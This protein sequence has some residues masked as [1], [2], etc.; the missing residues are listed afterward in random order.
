MNE[1]AFSPRS[2]NPKT[3]MTYEKGRTR[4]RQVIDLPDACEAHVEILHYSCYS[5]VDIC[6]TKQDMYLPAF[7]ARLNGTGHRQSCMGLVDEYLR[8][9]AFRDLHADF[10]ELCI[11]RENEQLFVA[12]DECVAGG[13]V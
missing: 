10:N 3:Y 8:S 2:S 9:P 1:H 7:H 11:P 13:A 4:I 12:S 6:I 5:F